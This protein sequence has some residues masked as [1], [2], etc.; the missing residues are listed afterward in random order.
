MK[1]QGLRLSGISNE[2]QGLK[3]SQVSLQCDSR[4]SIDFSKYPFRVCILIFL[5]CSFKWISTIYIHFG[6]ATNW[7]ALW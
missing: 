5:C 2:N 7:G 6:Q 3:A 4:G 1:S